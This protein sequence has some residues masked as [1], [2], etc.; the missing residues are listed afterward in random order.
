MSLR[1]VHTPDIITSISLNLKDSL[2]P[3]TGCC[4]PHLTPGNQGA[5]ACHYQLLCI[6]LVF[7]V[8]GLVIDTRVASFIKQ[9]DSEIGQCRFHV[10]AIHSF[11]Y[12]LLLCGI[13]LYGYTTFF[14]PFTDWHILSLFPGWAS[15][16]QSLLHKYFVGIC[17]YFSWVNA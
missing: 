5:A 10:L 3:W 14:Y 12:F 17:L 7:Y 11:Y 8:N 9:T 2:S 15:H 1:D 13:F 6:S 4:S 16:E